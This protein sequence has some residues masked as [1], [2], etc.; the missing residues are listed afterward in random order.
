MKGAEEAQL[1]VGYREYLAGLPRYNPPTKKWTKLGAFIYL[2]IVRPVWSLL[3][4][5]THTNTGADGNVPTYIAWLVRSVIFLVWLIHDWIF[6][7]IF[8]P[9]DGRDESQRH[10]LMYTEESEKVAILVEEKVHSYGT[11]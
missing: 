6:A 3:D 8:G 11:I 2:A 9:G 10:I 7:P 5:I 4:K 1:P